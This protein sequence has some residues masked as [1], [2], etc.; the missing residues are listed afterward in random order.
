M[1]FL[2]VCEVVV[3]YGECVNRLPC[4]QD[5]FLFVLIEDDGSLWVVDIRRYE[6]RFGEV[7][8]DIAR[9]SQLMPGGSQLDAWRDSDWC[10][11]GA[12][13]MSGGPA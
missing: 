9:C 7:Q 12:S 5:V 8:R 10:L 13:L 1:S 4:R 11:E 3:K 2:D 6:A